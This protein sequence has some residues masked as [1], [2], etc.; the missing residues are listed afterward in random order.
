MIVGLTPLTLT[1]AASCTRCASL[2]NERTVTVNCVR[3]YIG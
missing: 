2:N 3:N 1:A